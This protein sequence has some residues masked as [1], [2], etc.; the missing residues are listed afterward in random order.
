MAGDASIRSYARLVQDGGSAIV[1]NSPKR[2]DGPAIYDGK[3]YSAA[4]H[5]AED[6][7]PFVAMAQGLRERGFSTPVILHADLDAGFLITEDLGQAGVTEGDPP[8]PIPAR[9]EAATDLLAA[10]HLK[11]LPDNLPVLPQVRQV[12]Y[13]IPIF[14]T[15]ALLVEA[16]LMLEWYLPDRGI[17]PTNNLIADFVMMWRELLQ[18]P[19]EAAKTWVLRDFHSPN[20]IWL[21][22]RDG[23]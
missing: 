21:D 13:R 23:I 1:M 6:V 22:D 7:R 9:Y 11:S 15:D 10:L 12:R 4:V 16:G 3:S 14:D 18:R 20:L 5:L 19:M 2:P 8:R 17:K